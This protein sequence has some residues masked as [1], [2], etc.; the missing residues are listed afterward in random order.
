MVVPVVGVGVVRMN[1]LQ[2]VVT[3]W[4]VVRLVSSLASVMAVPVVLVV[5]VAMRMY[6][7]F[8][9]VGVGVSPPENDDESN[10]EDHCC[11]E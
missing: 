8:V 5:I 3:V 11:Q 10:Y 1:V 4:M 2:R 6:R 9:G 7:C